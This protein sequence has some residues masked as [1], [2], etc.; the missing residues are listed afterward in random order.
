MEKLNAG[1]RVIIV[2]TN[3]I[4]EDKLGTVLE[5]SSKEVIT[6]NGE[7]LTEVSVK[8]DFHSDDDEVKSVIQI[9]PRQN[10]KLNVSGEVKENMNTTINESFTNVNS[11][12]NSFIGKEVIFLGLNY[13]DIYQVK[14]VTKEKLT[15]IEE[16]EYDESDK[17]EIEKYKS[18]EGKTGRIV[19]CALADGFEKYNTTDDNFMS[20]YWDIYFKDEDITLENLSGKV[21][22]LL[23][24][25]ILNEAVEVSDF[26][27]IDPKE[28]FI[29]D[30][31]YFID[32]ED[33]EIPSWYFI[34]KIATAENI[35][36]N[37]VIEKALELKYKIY[38]IETGSGEADKLI[39]LAPK[40]KLEDVYT[41]YIDYIPGTV[42]VTEV[43]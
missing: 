30:Y 25:E 5:Q 15:D 37:T 42:T 7:D 39:I 32:I 29:H 10:L 4:W 21:L 16:F 19:A 17:E 41:D 28:D 33:K 20:C 26:D 24:T 35:D 38:R 22:S 6:T 14:K 11:F 31:V 12:I 2:D 1:D 43:I 27:T 13:E 40:A 36:E 23:D 8:V 3:D 34:S 9:F 18:L